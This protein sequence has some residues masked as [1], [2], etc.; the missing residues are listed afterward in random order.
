V[1]AGG[2]KV[3]ASGKPIGGWEGENRVR[4]KDVVTGRLGER[5]DKG[6]GIERGRGSRF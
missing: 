1:G 2:K 5:D 6:G 3:P 4:R